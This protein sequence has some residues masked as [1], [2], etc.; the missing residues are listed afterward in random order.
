MKIFISWSGELGRNIAIII[1]NWLPQINKEFNTFSSDE[2]IEKGSNWLNTI[3]KQLDETNFMINIITKDAL[4][5]KWQFYEFGTL[6]NN[7]G[8][9]NIVSII[10]DVNPNELPIPYS[11]LFLCDFSKPTFHKLVKKLNNESPIPISDK[12][13]E[14]KFKEYWPYLNNKYN[15]LINYYLPNKFKGTHIQDHTRVLKSL[16]NWLKK[17]YVDSDLVIKIETPTDYNHITDLA[18]IQS[19]S[20][21]IHAFEVKLKLNTSNLN[22]MVWSL[23]SFSSNYKWLVISEKNYNSIKGIYT[24]LRKY[25]IGLIL[26]SG[27]ERYSFEIKLRAKYSIG[28]FIEFW[29]QLYSEWYGE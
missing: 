16:K 5:S 9:S 14:S 18:M 1:K 15:K 25:G 4:K 13:I 8:H 27:K 28:N 19:K 24:T 2:D 23:N 20:N 7:I 21:N 22:S 10:V 12:K 3:Q 26:F 11:S 6:Y 17:H 29:P